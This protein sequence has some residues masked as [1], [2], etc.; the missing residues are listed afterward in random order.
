MRLFTFYIVIVLLVACKNARKEKPVSP[1]T[2]INPVKESDLT[3]ITLTGK[4]VQRLGIQTEVISDQT[5]SSSRLFSGEIIA[6]PGQAVTITAPVAGTLLGTSQSIMPGQSVTKG[7][8]MFRLVILPSEKDLLSAQEEVAQ[9]KVQFDVATEKVKRATAMYEEKSGSLRAKQEAEGELATVAAQLKVANARVQLLRGNANSGTLS[10]LNL[11]APISGTILKIYSSTSQVLS[12]GAPIADIVRL[13]PVWVKVP[14]YAGDENNV[15]KNA[16][17][18]IQTL[19]QSSSTTAI[20]A[21][22]IAGPQT[23]DP[24]ATSIDLYYHLDN[25]KNEFRPGQKVSVTLPMTGS[26]A[27]NT[28]PFSAIVYDI[29]GGTWVYENPSPNVFIRKRVELKTVSN[30]RAVLTRGP[31]AGTKIVTV[32][33]AELFG[34]EFGGG[35]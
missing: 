21:K 9:R 33:V 28:I 8:A 15:V 23:S 18:M 35:K 7:Q 12:A 32:G 22:R 3:K 6:I 25:S 27:A 19:S 1:S 13:D 10:T 16:D 30:G 17:A 4:A 11:Q 2:I 34:T 31:A 29:Q 5:V 20:S 26:E 14:L 24:L